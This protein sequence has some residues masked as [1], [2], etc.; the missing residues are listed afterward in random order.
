MCLTVLVMFL[1]YNHCSKC[2]TDFLTIFLIKVHSVLFGCVD[3]H[4]VS[5]FL[6]YSDF[7]LIADVS[8]FSGLIMVTLGYYIKMITIMMVLHH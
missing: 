8:I 4:T 1:L 5:S 2:D 6:S 3:I 7:L